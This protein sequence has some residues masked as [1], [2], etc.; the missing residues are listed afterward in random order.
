MESNALSDPA[1]LAQAVRGLAHDAH[2]ALTHSGSAEALRG[3]IRRIDVVSLAVNDDGAGSLGAWLRSL[4]R[5]VRLALAATR[6]LPRPQRAGRPT[7][8][9]A[10]QCCGVG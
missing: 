2:A 8:A 5:E 3:L 4:R 7:R 10:N 6:R 9:H 1:R